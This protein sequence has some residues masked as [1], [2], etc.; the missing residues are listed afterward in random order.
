MAACYA[1]EVRFSDPIFPD[2]TGDEPG[3]MW[4]MLT[5]R[6]TDLEARLVSHAATAETG[7]A[8]W[9]ADY[10][11]NGRRVHNDVN[12]SFRF[13]DGLIVEHHDSFPFNVWAR[14]A[15]GPVG[16]LLGWTPLLRTQVQRQAH[17]QLERFLGRSG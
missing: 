15:L 6:A 8:N 13:K 17:A 1:P 16:V 14:Q 4:R 10:V 3:A 7:N 5:A 2:L 11:V 9:I 12:A